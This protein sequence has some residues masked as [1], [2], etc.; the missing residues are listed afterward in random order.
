MTGEIVAVQ[1][2]LWPYLLLIVVGFL[3]SEIW[4]V[5]GVFLAQGPRR[6]RRDHR[7][8]PRGRHDPARRRRRQAAD[9]PGR[10][11]GPGADRGP[12]RRPPGRLRG[13]FFLLRRSVV[14]GILAAEAFFVALAWWLAPAG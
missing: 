2:G 1:G 6:A 13:A 7:F 5:L 10:A 9:Q 11:S 4:R 3:P 14:G 12:L 8:R